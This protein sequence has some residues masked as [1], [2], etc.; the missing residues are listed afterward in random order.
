ME[1]CSVSKLFKDEYPQVELVKCA[2]HICQLSA[3]Y[4]WEA[5]PT[6]I[7][8]TMAD[9]YKF[10]NGSARR[11]NLWFILQEAY[12]FSP[13]NILKPVFTRWL[14]TYETLHRILSKWHLLKIF[15][16]MESENQDTSTINKS[17][18]LDLLRKFND[19]FLKLHLLFLEYVLKKYYIANKSMQQIETSIDKSGNAMTNLYMELMKLYIKESKLSEKLCD[20]DP[21]DELHFKDVNDIEMGRS[22]S[23]YLRDTQLDSDRLNIFRKMAQRFLIIACKQLKDRC[24][25]TTD[26]WTHHLQYLCPKNAASFKFHHDYPT[27]N[28]LLNKLPS[29]MVNSGQIDV[30]NQEW[31]NL[32][33]YNLQEFKDEKNIDIFWLKIRDADFN[34]KP[35]AQN[36][37]KLSISILKV[38]VSIAEAERSHHKWNLEKTPIRNRLDFNMARATVLASQYIAD[39][40]EIY[41]FTPSKN[42]LINYIINNPPDDGKL[43]VD[44]TEDLLFRDF[45]TSPDLLEKCRKDAQTF[46]KHPSRPRLNKLINLVN[47]ENPSIVD[48]IYL[49]SKTHSNAGNEEENGKKEKIKRAHNN[50]QTICER[51]YEDQDYCKSKKLRS[52]PKYLDEDMI[53]KK[54]ENTSDSITVSTKKDLPKKRLK[55]TNVKIKNKAI[56]SPKVM[57][58]NHA[59]TV[60]KSPNINLR[61]PV[62]LNGNIC[63][64]KSNSVMYIFTV[65]IIFIIIL[66]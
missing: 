22:V 24:D 12:G 64:S 13:H 7:Q 23:D 58:K 66:F 49:D 35:I 20:I 38:A 40:G 60:E 16:Y 15:F 33:E 57:L 14:S 50:V 55:N 17:Q 61:I 9:V 19:P 54:T 8:T 41:N 48:K 30:I 59:E 31:K 21:E 46:Q 18:A 36:L 2:C 47:I 37:G 4:A 45:E 28:H 25:I 53:F 56:S 43:K 63:K 29:S 34:G 6:S 3:K 62:L 10:I 5:F 44:N 32:L 65:Y 26:D 1:N 27:L 11:M 51:P 52:A 42:M 39:R